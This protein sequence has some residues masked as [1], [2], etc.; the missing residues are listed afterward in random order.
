LWCDDAD[1][2]QRFGRLVPALKGDKESAWEY[3]GPGSHRARGGRDG[4]A[5]C[6]EESH[7]G[8]AR[9]RSSCLLKSA[10]RSR[11]RSRESLHSSCPPPLEVTVLR[12]QASG[13]GAMVLPADEDEASR[14]PLTL[15]GPR[16]AR[17]FLG[18][19]GGPACDAHTEI[20]DEMAAS[21]RGLIAGGIHD[22]SKL[23]HTARCVRSL[24]EYL[25]QG[26]VRGCTP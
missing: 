18:A 8:S 3:K 11:S 15:Y 1:I 17:S 25:Q 23:E 7:R 12:M 19:G 2:D 22:V 14:A 26:K 20:L 6:T 16:A 10:L 24:R 4:E 13:T 9:G 21:L 5:D